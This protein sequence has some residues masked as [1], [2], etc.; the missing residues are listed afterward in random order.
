MIFRDRRQA[1]QVV[2]GHLHD[3]HAQR[4]VV[5]ALP[6]GGV[7]VAHEVASALRAPLDVLVVRKVGC[8]WQRELAVGAIAEGGTLHLDDG[9]LAWLGIER[10]EL[11]AIVEE[12]TA[13]LDRRV[14]AYRQER[15]LIDVGERSVVVV[16]DGIATGETV[17]AAVEALRERGARHIVVAAPVA[18]PD[19]VG[20]LLRVA[21]RVECATLPEPFDAIGRFYD[22]F[23]AVDDEEVIALLASHQDGDA[24][25]PAQDVD[26]EL[27]TV[28][29]PGLMQQ[30]ERAHGI[31]IF[32][33]G[34][35]S[36]RL[37]PRN[38]QVARHLAQAG[39][40]TLLFDLLTPDEDRDR[41]TRF[42]IDLLTDRLAAATRWL[43]THVDP[44]T[45]PVGYFGAS[46]GSA[47]AL[48]AAAHPDL[49]IQAVVSRGGRPD[50]AAADLDRVTAPTLLIV[51]GNDHT[52]VR[53]NEQAAAAMRCEHTIEIVPGAGHLFEEPGALEQ[54][55]DLATAWFDRHLGS[56]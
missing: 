33:H 12:E 51:G 36:S 10:A 48:R 7:P 13:E 22:D 26:V 35:G 27:P 42:D 56:S 11:R 8:P 34:A 37:S 15:E 41:A 24:P 55:A 30:P 17:I 4:P 29:L 20:T 32:A 28:R 46:T 18:P 5:I 3:L 31:V 39:Y 1:G 53:L 40:G 50:L 21:D 54:V 45:T 52:V 44:A 6:R 16:D 38:R 43:T 23:G 49:A 2:A 14:H 19:V 47:A 25:A 9:L